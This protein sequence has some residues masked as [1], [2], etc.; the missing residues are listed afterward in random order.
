MTN[1]AVDMMRPEGLVPLAKPLQRPNYTAAG[2]RRRVAR[3]MAQALTPGFRG[4][5]GPG[6]GPSLL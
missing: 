4:S 6:L 2:G 3:G 5:L 1:F